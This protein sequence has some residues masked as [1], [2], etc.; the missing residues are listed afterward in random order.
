[1]IT[2][3]RNIDR[4]PLANDHSLTSLR[5]PLAPDRARIQRLSNQ[6]MHLGIESLRHRGSERGL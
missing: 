3:R 1:M 5:I 4:W 2:R 6:D